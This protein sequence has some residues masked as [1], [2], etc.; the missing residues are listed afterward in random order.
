MKRRETV[1]YITDALRAYVARKLLAV[2]TPPD[3]PLVVELASQNM[4]SPAVGLVL[5]RQP[6]VPNDVKEYFAAVI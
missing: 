6:E 5:M 1:S 2:E 4:V 3:W